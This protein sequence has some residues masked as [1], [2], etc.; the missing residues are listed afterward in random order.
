MGFHE[1][2][3]AYP[4]VYLTDGAGGFTYDINGLKI[5]GVTGQGVTYTDNWYP[6]VQYVHI[7]S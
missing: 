3:I 2:I 7:S 4:V 5:P 6:Y 1:K